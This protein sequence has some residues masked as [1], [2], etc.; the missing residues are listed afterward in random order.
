MRFRDNTHHNDVS[1]LAGPAGHDVRAADGEGE[2]GNG[3][4]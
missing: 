2:V 3:V 1:C 4:K